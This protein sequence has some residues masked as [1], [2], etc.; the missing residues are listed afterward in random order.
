ML[1]R[2]R[3]SWELGKASWA[4]LTSNPTL[5]LFPIL[6]AFGMLLTT[7]IIGGV[8]WL[9]IPSLEDG[10]STD[11]S[12]ENA[13]TLIAIVLIALA[14]TIVTVYFNTALTGAVLRQ[15]DGQPATLGDGIALAN[16]RKRAIV[17]WAVIAATFGLLMA[18]LRDKAGWAGRLIG[19]LGDLA[20]G[21]ATFFVVPVLAA[22]N[23][24]PIEALKRSGQL[25]RRTWGEQIAGNV[26]IGLFSLIIMLPALILGAVIVTLGIVTGSLVVTVIAVLLAVVVIGGAIAVGAALGSIYR[27]VLFRWATTGE[28]ARGFDESTLA[29]AFV[30]KGGPEWADPPRPSGY[31]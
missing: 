12:S 11:I 2:L 26:G 23:V 24:G 17:G 28:A 22:Q 19:A 4:I 13:P 25:F 20:W 5:A 18:V 15:L 1:D 7:A 9:T 3:R 10:V 16:T 14:G 30:R 29:G 31:I 27:T 8:S 21:F 6:A